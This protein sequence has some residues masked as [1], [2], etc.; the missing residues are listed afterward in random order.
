MFFRKMKKV[1]KKNIELLYLIQIYFN[2]VIL[3]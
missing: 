1:K 3:K 2:L